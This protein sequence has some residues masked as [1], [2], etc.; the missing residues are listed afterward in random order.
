MPRQLPIV[1]LLALFASAAASADEPGPLAPPD[2]KLD[3]LL[4]TWR[5]KSLDSLRGVWGKEAEIRRRGDNAVHV[6][7]RRVKVRASILGNISIYNG[8]GLEC[9]ALFE[10]NPENEIVRVTRRGGGRD[11]WNAFRR[12]EP[13]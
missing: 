9:V 1:V 8:P 13:R 7:E 2:D 10:V 3:Y 4:S 12:N 6:F 5:G 11:C